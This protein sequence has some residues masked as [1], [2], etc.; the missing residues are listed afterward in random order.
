MILSVL[1]GG[2]GTKQDLKSKPDA[3]GIM[4]IEMIDPV[5]VVL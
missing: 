2:V 4:A 5:V 3:V 1:M